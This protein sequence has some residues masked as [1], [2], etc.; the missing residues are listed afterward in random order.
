MEV[1]ITMGPHMSRAGRRPTT[2]KDHITNVA[3]EMFAERG[4]E[5]VSV[6]DIAAAAGIGR[7]TLFHYYPSKNAIPWGDF[8][9]H[10][11]NMH[12]FLQSLRPE[13]DLVESLRTALLDFNKFDDSEIARHRARM[14]IILETEELQAYSMTMYAGWR[15]VI[16]D[17]VASRC[18]AQPTDLRPQTVAW[19]MLGV[20]MSAYEVWLADDTLSLASTIATAFEVA[21]QPLRTFPGSRPT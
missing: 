2:S 5:A 18:G 7:R 16:A 17:F 12:D 8:D 14:R 21:S 10:V 1:L 15:A 3:I 9:T 4:F 13:A 6:D 11:H 20:A 19:T